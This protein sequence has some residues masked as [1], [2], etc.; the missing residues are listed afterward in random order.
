M[1]KRRLIWRRLEL[2]LPLKHARLGCGGFS[3][4]NVAGV[5]EA[6]GECGVSQWIGGRKSGERQCRGDGLLEP[7]GI[8]ECADE[9]VMGFDVRGQHGTTLG[10]AERDGGA[11]CFDDLGGRAGGQQVHS[12]PA[13]SFD[14]GWLVH[15]HGFL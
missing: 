15:G 3:L 14:F 10:F 6:D 5:L 7:A 11:E 12:L 2:Q 8:A 1:R 4:G 9:A 13:E